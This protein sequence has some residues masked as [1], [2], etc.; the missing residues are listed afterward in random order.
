MR[1]IIILNYILS[2]ATEKPQGSTV[3]VSIEFG[4]LLDTCP[5][6]PYRKY[7]EINSKF[8]EG[9]LFSFSSKPRVVESLPTG[10]AIS[11]YGFMGQLI[12]NPSEL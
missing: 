7:L 8:K 4:Q 11:Y 9:L 3:L 2:I 5:V 1:T 6:P 12:S 10:F